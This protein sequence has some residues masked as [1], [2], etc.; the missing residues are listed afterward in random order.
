[1]AFNLLFI[2]KYQYQSY[3]VPINPFIADIWLMIKTESLKMIF[4]NWIYNY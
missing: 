3:H 4:K 1:M 2:K